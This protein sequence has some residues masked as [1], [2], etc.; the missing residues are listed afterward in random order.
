MV[1]PKNQYFGTFLNKK[2]LRN[3]NIMLYFM[4]YVVF[5]VVIDYNLQKFVTCRLIQPEIRKIDKGLVNAKNTPHL[6]MTSHQIVVK[7][8]WQYVV[9][10]HEWI[11]YFE[12]SVILFSFSDILSLIL[13][14]RTFDTFNL[15]NWNMLNVLKLL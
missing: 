12:D 1:L 15:L 13:L 6:L 8:L 9:L 5:M 2:E 3:F 11:L 10:L 4:L 14:D 7:S